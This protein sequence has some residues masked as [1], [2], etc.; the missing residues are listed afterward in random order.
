MKGIR[1]LALKIDVLHAYH[2]YV[3]RINR[4]TTGIDRGSF[5]HALRSRGI[6]VN[7]HYVPVHMHPFYKNRFGTGRGLCPVAESAYEEIVSLPMYP[8][9]SDQDIEIVINTIRSLIGL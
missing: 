5:F 6:G 8:A 7:V 1:P 4:K 9:M 2:L 3:I